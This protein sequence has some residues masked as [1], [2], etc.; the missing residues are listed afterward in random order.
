M[1]PD[2]VK[3]APAVLRQNM[4][5]CR[6]LPAAEHRPPSCGACGDETTYDGDSFVCY[7]CGLA[8]D[9]DTLA[10]DYLDPDAATCAAPCNNPWHKPGQSK[11]A[12]TYTCGTCAL[13]DGHDRPCW[14]GC[15]WDAPTAPDG[16]RDT[17]DTQETR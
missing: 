7:D 13:P 6:T 10:A 2:G 17:N 3:A 11:P 8:F 1:T 5:V 9:P 14:T 4:A 12:R 15:T 16:S